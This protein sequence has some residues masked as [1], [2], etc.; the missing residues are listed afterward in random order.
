MTP[1]RQTRGTLPGLHGAGTEASD[2]KTRPSTPSVIAMLMVAVM[3]MG[4][5]VFPLWVISLVAPQYPQGL[6]LLIHVDHIEG[7][8]PFDLQNIN[9]VNHYIG[10][11]KID[12][13]TI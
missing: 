7:T 13:G 1:H 2:M 11:H 4:V 10:M 3:I 6:G 9:T 5:F 12:P 8:A